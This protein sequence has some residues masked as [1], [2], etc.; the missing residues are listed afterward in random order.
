VKPAVGS[1]TA[2]AGAFGIV[3]LC[4]GLAVLRDTADF[5]AVLRGVARLG[6]TVLSF[7]IA[8]TATFELSTLTSANFTLF[9]CC[10]LLKLRFHLRGLRL[11][12]LSPLDS[13]WTA[14]LALGDAFSE[15]PV[16]R[17]YLVSLPLT[18]Q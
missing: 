18:L 17:P 1:L 10:R 12:A 3:D 7:L 9:A 2:V 6:V 13:H 14:S 5:E 11:S 8:Y 16:Q 15:S 4:R